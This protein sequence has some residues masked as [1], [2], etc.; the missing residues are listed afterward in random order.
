MQKVKKQ[1]KDK[2][3]TSQIV[4]LLRNELSYIQF[5]ELNIKMLMLRKRNR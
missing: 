2:K 1:N 4:K 3:V 5:S